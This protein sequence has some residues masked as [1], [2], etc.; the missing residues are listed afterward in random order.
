M[1]KTYDPVYLA[2][3]GATHITA[4]ARLAAEWYRLAVVLGDQGAA[5]A[6][7]KLESW[8]SRNAG[9]PTGRAASSP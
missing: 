2:Q 6:L 3:V 7:R 1:A 8:K 5:T 9:P 4:D